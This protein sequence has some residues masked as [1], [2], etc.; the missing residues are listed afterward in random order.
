MSVRAK[1]KVTS[2]LLTE[3]SKQEI[4]TNIK[5]SAVTSGSKENESFFRYTPSASLDIGVVPQSVAD[6][7]E[8]GKEYYIDF[9]KA[10]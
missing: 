4:L 1:F 5:M 6:Q 9:T 7:F 10:E 8:L 2:K 3:G